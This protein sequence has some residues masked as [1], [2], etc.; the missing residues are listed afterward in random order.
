[1]NIHLEIVPEPW[2]TDAEFIRF[3]LPIYLAELG[4][5]SEYPY[6]E[7]YWSEPT[8]FPYLIKSEGE[9]IGFAFVRF[10]KSSG[11]WELAEFWVSSAMRGQGVGRSAFQLIFQLHTGLWRVSALV[12]NL[13]A[14]LFWSKI[15]GTP[16]STDEG[17]S[18]WRVVSRLGSA[19]QGVKS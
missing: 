13:P 6:L 18:T 2:S 10:D 1:V 11:E 3:N 14:I 5:G 17:Q 19:I 15:L 8:R 16:C 12:N 7:L 9:S 4:V